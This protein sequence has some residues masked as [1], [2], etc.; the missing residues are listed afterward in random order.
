MHGQERTLAH[1]VTICRDTATPRLQELQT[2]LRELVESWLRTRF[3]I[4]LA[5]Y[6]PVLGGSCLLWQNWFHAALD[7]RKSSK[8]AF[9]CVALSIHRDCLG[10][11][12]DREVMATAGLLDRLG[13]IR[14]L[15]V[16]A[17]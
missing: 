13:E 14:V 2:R 16:A 11:C 8:P 9:D 5:K 1:R 17:L 10:N 12:D 4:G 7:F 6:R 15:Y 3:S